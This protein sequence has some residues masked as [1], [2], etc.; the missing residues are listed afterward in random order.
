MQMSVWKL[1]Q[2]N[3][4][5]HRARFLIGICGQ[6][7]TDSKD[8]LDPNNLVPRGQYNGFVKALLLQKQAQFDTVSK[9]ASKL[10]SL[11][12]LNAASSPAQEV[13]AL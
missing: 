12:C 8:L 11:P 13:L 3:L 10:P 2:S 6:G 1:P 4:G 7:S 5:G 9:K